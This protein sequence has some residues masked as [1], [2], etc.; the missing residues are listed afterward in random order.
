[1]CL[2]AFNWMDH[3]V[4]KMVLVANRDEYFKRPTASLRLWDEGFYAGK[5]L[6]AGGTWMG[7]HPNGRFAA[8]TNFRD[9]SN[10]TP[11]SKSRGELIPKFLSG[12]NSVL[13]FIAHLQETKY[14]YN[15]F[16][17]LLAEQEEMWFVSNYQEAVQR[18]NPGLHGLSNALLNTPWPKVDMAKNELGGLIA[19]QEIDLEE[20]GSLLQ[21]REL[22]RDENLPS[23]GLSPRLEKAVSA[24]FIEVEDY[25]G[26][27]NT[28][29]LLWKHTGE[30][31][32]LE[33]RLMPQK[34]RTKITFSMNALQRN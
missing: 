5:D 31:E 3:P 25:Y 30:V 13:E 12:N 19:G 18:V 23:T 2:I 8:L 7:I 6:K 28:T 33:R 29:A 26:T 1:M 22:A 21:S 34:E 27:V 17:L 10:E 4:Y 9:I 11:D 15:G 20:V 16:N 14:Q 32:I 24:Q